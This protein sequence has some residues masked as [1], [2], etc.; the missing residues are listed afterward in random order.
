MRSTRRSALVGAAAFLSLE[1][2]VLSRRGGFAYV[3]IDSVV[4]DARVFYALVLAPAALAVIC[5]L[6]SIVPRI[7]VINIS[8]AVGLLTTLEVGARLITTAPSPVGE[9]QV[10][11]AAP[12]YVRDATLGYVLARSVTARHR[13]S[14][15]DTQLY[16]VTYRT[17][18]VGRR[19][20]STTGSAARNS[21]LVF[22]GDSNVFGE[23]LSQ[24]ETLP[25][26]AGEAA[27]DYRPYNYG[28]PGYGPSQALAIARR[29]DLRTEIKERSGYL[30]FFVIP[31][32][33][34]RVIGSSRV[35]TSWGRYFP[36]FV[37]TRPGE[38]TR[39]GD[40]AHGRP[41]TT[42][43]Y[44]FWTKSVLAERLD[45]ELPIWYTERDYRLTARVLQESSRRFAEQL[46]LRGSTIVL[47][48]VYDDV[49]RG[50]MDRLREALERERASYL[51]YTRLVDSS[52]PQYR[53]AERDYHN[54]AKANSI[55]ARRLVADLIDAAP[56][57]KGRVGVGASAP[58]STVEHAYYDGS[59]GR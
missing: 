21:F 43:A 50:M 54:S 30:V 18:A 34:S 47:A 59:R 2:L 8:V 14:I 29:G 58:A 42:L 35:S 44:F 48:Q 11:G 16:D 3:N 38:L 5:V 23:G 41:L 24:T 57:A 46:H 37:E 4:Q 56:Q 33:V 20:T 15:G 1:A 28:V 6:A 7:V 12:F 36:Y 10:D 13:R 45:V 31:A 51:D 32:H 17:D 27:P 22:F 9:P 26:F 40:F 19:E 52:D 49:Q 25:Y 39:A 53:L 55:I